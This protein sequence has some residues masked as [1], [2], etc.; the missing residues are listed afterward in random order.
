ML[1]T[2]EKYLL[3]ICGMLLATLV[4]LIMFPAMFP[5]FGEHYP[6]ASEGSEGAAQ[7]SEPARR[8]AVNLQGA[9]LE[10][11]PSVDKPPEATEGAPGGVS[12]SGPSTGELL[13][14]PPSAAGAIKRSWASRY[15]VIT[16]FPEPPVFPREDRCR[17]RLRTSAASWSMASEARFSTL[18]PENV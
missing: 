17:Y 2:Y 9:A 4:A 3:V 6:D 8:E 1:R 5:A 13:C 18:S 10:D 7:Q 11:K 12:G 16:E 15:S 14:A